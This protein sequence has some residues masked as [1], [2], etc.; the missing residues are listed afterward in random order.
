MKFRVLLVILGATLMAMAASASD[1]GIHG[2]YYAGDLKQWAV[3]VDAQ[4]PIGPVAIAPNVDYSRKDGISWW[5]ASADLDLRWAP[6][7]GPS[8]WF[9]AGPSYGRVSDQAIGGNHDSEW[10]WDANVGAGWAM[11]G[12][13]PYVQGRYQKIKD[14]RSAGGFV[15][16]RF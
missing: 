13:K 1:F 3:G 16:V 9:G 10:G 4:Y 5:F 11:G 8:F 6:G 14:F 7:S 2:G 15:G 12:L